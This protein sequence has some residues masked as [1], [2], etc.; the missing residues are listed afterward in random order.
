MSSQFLCCNIFNYTISL[1]QFGW[2][3]CFGGSQAVPLEITD[4]DLDA[5][6]DRTRGTA[7]TTKLSEKTGS[8]SE[9]EAGSTHS[10]TSSSSSSSSSNGNGQSSVYEDEEDEV[11]KIEIENEKENNEKRSRTSN[12]SNLQEGMECSAADFRESTPFTSIRTFEVSSI[13]IATGNRCYCGPN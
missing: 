5:I 2:N 4:S 3:A 10:T 6:L 12:S 9:L 8:T 11:F 1:T 13:I 7:V